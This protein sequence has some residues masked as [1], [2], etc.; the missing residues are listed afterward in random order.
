M[1]LAEKQNNL[2]PQSSENDK[3]VSNAVL[4]SNKARECDSDHEIIPQHDKKNSRSDSLTIQKSS[5]AALFPKKVNAIDLNQLESGEGNINDGKAPRTKDKKSAVVKPLDQQA[6]DAIVEFAMHTAELKKDKN[7]ISSP[8][9]AEFLLALLALGTTGPAHSEL[10]TSLG[11]PDDD[12]IRSLFS[13]LTS[14]V[15]SLKGVTLS[16][17]NKVYI[18]DGE[19]DLDTKVKED[20]VAIFDSEM[21]KVN[22][23][24]TVSVVSNVNEWVEKKT[25]N[26]IKNL[27]STSDVGSSTRL[28]LVNAIYFKGTWKDQFNPSGTMKHPFYVNAVTTVEV[29]MMFKQFDYPYGLSEELQAQLLDIPYIDEE[30]SMLIV[31]PEE[32]E[33]LNDIMVKLAAGYDLFADVEKMH[34]TTVRVTI[35]KFKIETTIDLKILLPELGISTIFN[36]RNSGITKLLNT[37]EGFYV[38][39]AVQKAFIEVN[40]EGAEAAAATKMA[41]KKRKAPR[42]REFQADRPYLYLLLSADRVPLFI[43]VYRGLP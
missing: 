5:R 26:K 7:V 2:L 42:Y 36:S 28:V 33:G 6:K 43:G 1:L 20:A 40:E 39:S 10:L 30:A 9:S 27:L 18:Q 16:I 31:L 38:S 41:I 14:K 25:N 19:Y 22:F 23:S 34:K 4:N 24:D 21:E 37:D 29:P 15:K 11:F 12:S 13:T 35:P 3:Q 8:L 32:M 17:A